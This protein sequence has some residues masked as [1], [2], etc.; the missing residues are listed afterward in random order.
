M[1]LSRFFDLAVAAGSRVDPRSGTGTVTYPDSAIL[2]GKG[3]RD[4]SSVFVGIDVDVQELLLADRLRASLR[5]DC[6]LSHHPSGSAFAGLFKVLE[7]QAALLVKAGLDKRSAAGFLEERAREVERKILPANHMRAVD[8]A[9]LLDIPFV[10]IHTPADN[11]AAWYIGK[12]LAKR[13]PR[14][15]KDVLAALATVNEYRSATESGAGP[16]LIL[17]HPERAAGRI[18]VEMT[19]GTEGPKDAYVPMQKA[20]IS[21]LVSMH[22]GEDHLKKIRSCGLNAVIAGHIS[23]DTLGMNLLLDAIEKEERLKFV[24]AS[25]FRRFHH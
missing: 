20:G 7:L 22:I 2:Y 11:L 17:G 13:R 3:S 1:K 10:C 5:I 8:A 21:T 6:V 9:R 19:G 12:L 25:G 23:S 16:R 18:Y 15:V 14:R 4:I 24:C